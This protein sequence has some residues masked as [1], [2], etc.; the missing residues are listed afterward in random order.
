MFPGIGQAIVKTVVQTLAKEVTSDGYKV[1][2][3]L[4]CGK[5]KP[6]STDQEAEV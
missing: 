6:K 1:V 3:K 4:I 2:K 5:P